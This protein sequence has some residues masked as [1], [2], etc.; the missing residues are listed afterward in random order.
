LSEESEEPQMAPRPYW[1]GYLKLSLVTCA[2]SLTPATTAGEKVSFH[3]LNARTGNRVRS[4]YVDAETGKPVSDD[5]EVRGYETSAGEFVLVEDEEIEAM[6]LESTRTIDIDRFVPADG[7]E[8]IYFDSAYYLMPDDEVA[9]EAYAVIREAM[10]ASKVVGIS[11]LVLSR[12]ERA[13]MLQPWGKGIVLRTLRYGDEV[14][15]PSE[16]FGDIGSAKADPKALQLVGKLIDKLTAPWDD[17]RMGDPVQA[18]LKDIV[19]AKAKGKAKSRA[20]PAKD[21][22]TAASNVV[23]IMDA[24]KKSIAAEKKR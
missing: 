19:A 9:Q 16:A 21:A 10:R 1:K 22:D 14:R 5:D 3:T 17:A 7:I 2:V 20:R 24:L 18:K 4:R 8:W 6:G 12:R 15:D 11:R 23:N 13:V